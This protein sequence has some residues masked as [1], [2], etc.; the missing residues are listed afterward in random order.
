MASASP[1]EITLA[2][3]T[4]KTIKVPRQGRGRPKTRPKRLIANKA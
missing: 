4:L 3:T 1:A 2:E